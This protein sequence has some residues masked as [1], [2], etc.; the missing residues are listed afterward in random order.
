MP[1]EGAGRP[2]CSKYRIVTL[3]ILTAL[4]LVLAFAKALAQSRSKKRNATSQG[5]QKESGKR[6][7]ME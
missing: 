4:L 7:S 3:R 6:K 2:D 1:A 5:W